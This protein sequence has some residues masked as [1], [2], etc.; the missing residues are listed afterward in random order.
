MWGTVSASLNMCGACFVGETENISLG[1]T[2]AVRK[3]PPGARQRRKMCVSK[4]VVEKI[5]QTAI[6]ELTKESPLHSPKLQ[7][8]R[9]GTGTQGGGEGC[10]EPPPSKPR[11]GGR[12]YPLP[13]W[14][15]AEEKWEKIAAQ[16]PAEKN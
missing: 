7:L 3:V 13:S 10:P 4:M 14:S 8:S 16:S 5:K 15:F 6:R 12:G 11:G 2:T 9:T 1:C